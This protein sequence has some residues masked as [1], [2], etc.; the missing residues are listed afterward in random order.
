MLSADDNKKVVNKRPK[1]RKQKQ[2]MRKQDRRY[3]TT[4]IEENLR[5]EQDPRQV[6]AEIDLVRG[7]SLHEPADELRS[8]YLRDD[9]PHDHHRRHHSDDDRE[10]FLCIFFT[11]FRQKARVD[12]NE[13]DGGGAPS[14]DVVEKI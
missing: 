8:E 3:H 1:R 9:C 14:D 11:F 7:K 12:R 10:G 4:D 5:W 2:P 13:S 6:N